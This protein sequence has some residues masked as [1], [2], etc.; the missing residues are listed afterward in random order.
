MNLPNKLT[1][2]RMILIPVFMVFLMMGFSYVAAVIF[3]VASL[4]DA[5]DGH[6]ARKYNLITNFGKIMDPLA[7][8]LLVTA[9]LL[10]L[11]QLGHVA[12]WM[13]FVILAREF[14]IVSLRAVAASQ[15]IVIAASKWGKLKTISQMAAVILLLM[16][17]WPFGW[18]CFPLADIVMWIAVI[19]TIVSG[20]DYIIKNKDVFKG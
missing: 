11:V 20:V 7:D 19:L 1:M 6:I 5:L 8:K 17:N 12:A 9:A 14:L 18:E 3:I 2:L 16:E 4:T 13:V 15:G 10:C